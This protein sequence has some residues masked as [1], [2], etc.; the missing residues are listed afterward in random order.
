MFEMVRKIIPRTLK[1]S[2]HSNTQ[3]KVL[4]MQARK[5]ILYTIER[6]LIPLM[7]NKK[8]NANK[9]RERCLEARTVMVRKIRT[10]K[11]AVA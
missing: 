10:K 3:T 2:A 7:L 8:L 6:S 1:S 11:R 9:S 4:T 5:N